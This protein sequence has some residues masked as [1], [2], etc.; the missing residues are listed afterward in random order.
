MTVFCG[1]GG[2][3]SPNAS[4]D[5][6]GLI[7][8]TENTW[9]AN[10]FLNFSFRVAASLL[11]ILRHCQWDMLML[12][13]QVFGS[14]L[15]CNRLTSYVSIGTFAIQPSAVVIEDKERACD[16]LLMCIVTV[17]SHGLR[18]GGGVGDVLRK[19]SK[20]VQRTG[21]QKA[22][23]IRVYKVYRKY[24]PFAFNRSHCLQPE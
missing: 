8:Q 10:A 12:I 17:L 11:K 14:N 7:Q 13:R 9:Q 20:E 22:G 18:S 23:I 24:S 6:I 1:D 16:S 19:P 4:T 2:S 21:V 15:C 3:I 5:L